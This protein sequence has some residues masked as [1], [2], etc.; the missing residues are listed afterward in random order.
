MPASPARIAAYD[1]LLR[2]ERERA[3]A[4]ELLHS[5]LLDSLS[6]A[7]RALCTEIVM[8]VL[9]WRARIDAEKSAE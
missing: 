1:I 5:A 6:P 8:G 7:D 4:D 2:V 9:R 3:Y